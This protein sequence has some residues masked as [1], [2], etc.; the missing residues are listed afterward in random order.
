MAPDAPLHLPGCTASEHREAKHAS[1]V[2][3][4]RRSA[5]PPRVLTAFQRELG[6]ES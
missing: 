6:E 3:S 2:L 1:P 4:S 5:H